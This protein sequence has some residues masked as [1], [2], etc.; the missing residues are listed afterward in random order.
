MSIEKKDLAQFLLEEGVLLFGEFTLKSGRQSPHFFNSGKF[1]SGRALNKL[2]KYYA[3]KIEDLGGCDIIFGPAYKGIPLSVAI[4]TVRD[5]MFN[6]ETGVLFD[7]KE[8]KDHGDGGLF[9][10]R[11]PTDASKLILVDDVI[12]SGISLQKSIVLLKDVFHIQPAFALVAV[13]RQEKGRRS[14]L[15]AAKEI[16]QA[17]NLPLHSLIKLTEVVELMEGVEVKGKVLIDS[18]QK[19]KVLNYLK[20]NGGQ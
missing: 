5:R 11:E 8:V 13:D 3:H 6:T 2:G 10:G 12:S 15:S 7:R 17:E 4:A 18:A 19:E 9:V 1:D 14:E 16:E 20:E